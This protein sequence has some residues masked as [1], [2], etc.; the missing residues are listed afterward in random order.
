MLKREIAHFHGLCHPFDHPHQNERDGQTEREWIN[1]IFYRQI[2]LCCV[3]VL[4]LNQNHVLLG[5]HQQTISLSF[6]HEFLTYHI[7]SFPFW[8]IIREH[9]RAHISTYE[10][11]F[12]RFIIRFYHVISFHCAKLGDVALQLCSI[13]IWI[14]VIFH[15]P[16]LHAY[17]L[18][19]C[20]LEFLC[21]FSTF[22]HNVYASSWE[23]C[24]VF[25]HFWIDANTLRSKQSHFS[26]GMRLAQ[27]NC[28]RKY[29]HDSAPF[30][31]NELIRIAFGRRAFKSAFKCSLPNLNEC[32]RLAR[33]CQTMGMISRICLLCTVER[34]FCVLCSVKGNGFHFAYGIVDWNDQNPHKFIIG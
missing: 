15:F 17:H 29:R 28:N 26:S 24:F 14:S 1:A 8:Q 11:E 20:E 16:C 31:D 7:D 5:Q 3:C 21:H 2:E 34:F 33:Y 4:D 30:T 12:I 19:H 6:A 27:D 25:C 18:V 10:H 23:L 13:S 32:M 22:K 9:N